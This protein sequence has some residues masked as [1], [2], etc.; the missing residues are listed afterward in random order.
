M[1]APPE[2][3]AANIKLWSLVLLFSETNTS[4]VLELVRICKVISF[5]NCSVFGYVCGCTVERR[6]M[7]YNEDTLSDMIKKI[8]RI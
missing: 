5:Q 6:F 2:N 8:Q 4:S 3:W 1:F 7:D